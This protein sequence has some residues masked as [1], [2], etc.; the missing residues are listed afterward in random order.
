MKFK[1]PLKNN[2]KLS[3]FAEWAALLAFC[4]VAWYGIVLLVANIIKLFM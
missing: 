4:A 1:N 3:F 2:R